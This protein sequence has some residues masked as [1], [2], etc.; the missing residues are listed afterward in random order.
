MELVVCGSAIDP[1]PVATVAE[2][3][4]TNEIVSIHAE[5]DNVDMAIQLDNAIHKSIRNVE[6]SVRL[7]RLDAAYTQERL[8]AA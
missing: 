8:R 5:G 1:R 3:K 7:L 2:H 6:E 4:P